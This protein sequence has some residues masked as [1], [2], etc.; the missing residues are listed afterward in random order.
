[1]KLRWRELL[2][3]F[4][5][6]IALWYGLAGSEKV[7]SLV[8]VRMDYRG[9]PANLV[10]RDGLV[11]KV[12]VRVRGPVGMLR[13]I[14]SRN[15][16]F[17]MDL[18]S[19]KKGL[20]TLIIPPESLPF[21]GGVEVVEV[22]PPR[23]QLDVDT[24]EKKDVP[25]ALDISGDLSEDYV[26]QA[27]STPESVSVRG[28]SSVIAAMKNLRVPV[29]LANGTGIGNQTLDV[30]LILPEGV[31]AT[32]PEVKVAVHVGLKRRL[33]T[34]VRS[35]QVTAPPSMGKYIRPDKV[36]ITAALPLSLVSGAAEDGDI[37]AFATLTEH[38]LGSYTLPV[39][40]HL[41][42]GA[43][44]VRVEPGQVAVTLEQKEPEIP[45]RR[46]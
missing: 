15:L 40:V 11:N 38:Q 37:F 20:N 28:P 45:H 17:S 2:I 18:S 3:A 24:V 41:P 34:I 25:L 36:R 10:I 31:D 29:R 32:P 21:R 30:P 33:V 26:V 4:L 12:S 35:V 42:E 16:L 9:V 46:R 8:D 22:T 6:A 7:E 44:L 27:S 19:L 43:E 5:M 1:M 23:I 13:S 14:D 39:H